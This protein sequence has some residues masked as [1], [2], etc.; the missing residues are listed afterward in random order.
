VFNFL[1]GSLFRIFTT[2]QEVDDPLILWGFIVACIL[3]AVI[4]AQMVYYWNGT[5][6]T[7]AAGKRTP[8]RPRRTKRRAKKQ[9]LSD[10]S[11]EQ[12]ESDVSS[13]DWLLGSEK[14]GR[15]PRPRRKA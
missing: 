1:A 14:K 11:Y 4:A 3:N 10:A 8:A 13:N 12:T 2:L 9:P 7:R 5:A 15:A 6:I